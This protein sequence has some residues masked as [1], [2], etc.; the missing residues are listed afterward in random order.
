[1]IKMRYPV[2]VL[3]HQEMMKMKMIYLTSLSQHSVRQD[4]YLINVG[5]HGSIHHLA[6]G[7][8]KHLSSSHAADVLRKSLQIRVGPSYQ[9]DL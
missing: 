2:T 9:N 7:W 4:S 1:M 8:S 5:L 6:K 3:C